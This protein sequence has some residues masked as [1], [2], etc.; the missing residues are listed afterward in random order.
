MK[1]LMRFL[2]LMIGIFLVGGIVLVIIG[3]QMVGWQ[4]MGQMVSEVSKGKVSFEDGVKIEFLDKFEAVLDKN[5]LFHIGDSDMFTDGK[6][7]WK[8]DVEK[9]KVASHTVEDWNLELGGCEFVVEPSEDE[10]Y[11]VEY[12]GKGKSQVYTKGDEL[13]VKVLN[14]SSIDFEKEENCFT[15]YVPTKAEL[16]KVEIELGAGKAS[17]NDICAKDVKIQVGAGE[18]VLEDA[19]FEKVKVEVGAGRCAIQGEV[20][21]DIKAECAM[22]SLEL[23][24]KGEEEDFN[25]DIETV[26]GSISVGNHE[27]SGLAKEKEIDHDADKKMELECAMGSIEVRFE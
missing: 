17:M 16:K 5:A 25:Y 20:N 23:K 1:K 18:L 11:Y 21:D 27:Y 22:G 4:G 8:G 19:E 10:S 3:W 13:F 9:T 14:S 24:L 12:R 2:G 15:L 26:S 6:E 7:V